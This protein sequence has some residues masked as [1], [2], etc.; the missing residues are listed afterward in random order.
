MVFPKK[1]QKSQSAHCLHTHVFWNLLQIVE[2]VILPVN[3]QA[4]L[5]PLGGRE[6]G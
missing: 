5:S 6:E 3:V 2:L 4:A 1:I